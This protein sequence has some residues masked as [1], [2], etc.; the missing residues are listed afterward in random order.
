VSPSRE[1]LVRGFEQAFDAMWQ[2]A[3]R[4]LG[5]VTLAAI[6]DRVLYTAA[7]RFP[8]L[9]PLNVQARGLGFEALESRI[10]DLDLAHLQA[11]I[12]S[13]MIEFL[14]V[15]GNLSA[16]VLTPALHSELRK[17]GPVEE[18][19]SGRGSSSSASGLDRSDVEGPE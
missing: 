15:L 2:R 6:V 1:E 4:T 16:E 14:T 5:E 11:G 7:E 18:T 13:V 3:V 17:L 10:A 8:F 12:R 9:E 19:G